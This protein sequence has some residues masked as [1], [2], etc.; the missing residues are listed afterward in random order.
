MIFTAY[1]KQE[2]FECLS[3]INHGKYTPL[4]D[5]LELTAETTLHGDLLK[6]DLKMFGKGTA[7]TPHALSWFVYTAL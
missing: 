2:N 6:I 5:I 1:Q 4:T 7:R 3:N